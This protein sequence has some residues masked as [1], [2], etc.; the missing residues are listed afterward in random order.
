[1]QAYSEH[2]VSPADGG[3]PRSSA[4]SWRTQSML[5]SL[6]ESRQSLHGRMARKESQVKAA[7]AIDA[8][9]FSILPPSFSISCFHTL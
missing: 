7:R 4:Y 2:L 9:P 6:P 3:L 1:M 8:T 5:G